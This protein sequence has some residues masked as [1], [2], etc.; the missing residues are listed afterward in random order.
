M[1]AIVLVKDGDP[2]EAFE[3][4]DISMPKCKLNDVLI[5]VSHFGL[6]YADI[7]AR[8]GMYNDRPELPCLLGYEVVGEVHDGDG[9]RR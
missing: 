6:N 3:F 4:Q 8:K 9:H 5:K 2:K 1:R 7:M